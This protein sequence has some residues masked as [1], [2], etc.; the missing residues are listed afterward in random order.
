MSL[1]ATLALIVI[2]AFMFV[3][4]WKTRNDKSI[5]RIKIEE[6]LNTITNVMVAV[7]YIIFVVFMLTH[8]K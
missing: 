5:K 8:V 6:T 3:I 1:V 7:S 4:K 2:T